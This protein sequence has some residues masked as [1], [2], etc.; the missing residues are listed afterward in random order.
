MQSPF[1][2]CFQSQRTALYQSAAFKLLESDHAYRCFCSPK[3]LEMLGRAQKQRG[4]NPGYDK[5]CRTLTSAEIEERLRR[6]EPYMI[7]FKVSEWVACEWG[8]PLHW[9][10]CGWRTSRYLRSTIDFPIMLFCFHFRVDFS[11][12]YWLSLVLLL[13]SRIHLVMMLRLRLCLSFSPSAGFSSSLTQPSFDY[14]LDET[15]VVVKD[16]VF[17]D[18]K[19]D[20]SGSESDPVSAVILNFF[21]LKSKPTS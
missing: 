12:A 20:L 21:S 5:K 15:D 14:Q 13:L 16:T 9:L 7:R 4:E 2:L 3:R 11:R 8:G 1:I 6:Q 10:A 17:G 19:A 18:V